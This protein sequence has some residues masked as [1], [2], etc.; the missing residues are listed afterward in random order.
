MYTPTIPTPVGTEVLIKLYHCKSGD[1][2]SVSEVKGKT[3]KLTKDRYSFRFDLPSRRIFFVPDTNGIRFSGGTMTTMSTGII[4][5]FCRINAVDKSGCGFYFLSQD[6]ATKQYYVD[7]RTKIEMT[8]PVDENEDT[9]KTSKQDTAVKQPETKLSP[10]DPAGVRAYIK[11]KIQ[12]PEPRRINSVRESMSKEG[13]I[14][15]AEEIYVAGVVL[16]KIFDAI[17][18]DNLAKAKV[19]VEIFEDMHTEFVYENVEKRL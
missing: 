13:E 3:K 4:K 17:K 7:T 19:L 12:N 14:L 1:M 16:N 15:T 5:L 6:P 2:I 8:P 9:L 11:E 10:S 18:D